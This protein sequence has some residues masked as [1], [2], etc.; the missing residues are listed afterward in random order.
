LILGWSECFWKCSFQETRSI[1]KLISMQNIYFA[2]F[3]LLDPALGKSFLI[4]VDGKMYFTF[5]V[6][7]YLECRWTLIIV[8]LCDVQID[9][10]WLPW[11]FVW[12]ASVWLVE[13]LIQ[14]YHDFP[15][16]VVFCSSGSN[17]VEQSTVVG[18]EIGKCGKV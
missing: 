9:K 17:F 10:E 2:I 4:G 11:L 13:P 8:V 1:I 6:L 5:Y 3:S 12:Y 16:L 14:S 18:Q 15:G 7:S